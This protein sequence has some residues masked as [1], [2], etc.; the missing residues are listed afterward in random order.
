[1]A[2]GTE[3]R[4]AKHCPRTVRVFCFAGC[5]GHQIRLDE[6]DGNWGRCKPDDSDRRANEIRDATVKVD[7]ADLWN[8][9]VIKSKINTD[10]LSRRITALFDWSRGRNPE[11]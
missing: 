4:Q 3:R 2:E 8:I 10:E 1:M 6:P 5:P 9:G 7:T 11:E